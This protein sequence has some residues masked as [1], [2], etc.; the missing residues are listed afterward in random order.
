MV[1][2]TPSRAQAA[3]VTVPTVN[4]TVASSLSGV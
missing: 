3:D 1:I 2:L 4:T